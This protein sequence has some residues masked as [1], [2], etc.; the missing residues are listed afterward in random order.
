MS[1]RFA[2]HLLATRKKLSTLLKLVNSLAQKSHTKIE[3]LLEVSDALEFP[4]TITVCGDAGT[5]RSEVA[6]HLL[7][8]KLSLKNKEWSGVDFSGK[9][10][11]KEVDYSVKRQEATSLQDIYCVEAPPCDLITPEQL[12]TFTEQLSKSDIILW[13]FSIDNPWSSTTWGNIE[14]LPIELIDRSVLILN[15]ANERSA[16]D[17]EVM[18]G[19]MQDLSSQRLQSTQTIFPVGTTKQSEFGYNELWTHVNQLLENSQRCNHDLVQARDKLHRVLDTIEETMDKRATNLDSDQ[20]FLASLEADIDRQRERE[21]QLYASKGVNLSKQFV[22]EIDPMLEEL[23]ARCGLTSSLFDLFGR[24]RLTSKVEKFLIDRVCASYVQRS[25]SDCLQILLDCK[26]QWRKMQDHLEERLGADV[27]DFEQEAFKSMLPELEL[28]QEKA[29]KTAIL[30]MKLRHTM[31]YLVNPRRAKLKNILSFNLLGFIV[32]GLLGTFKVP[33]AGI[34][35]LFI[36]AASSIGIIF[37]FYKVFSTRH[38]IVMAMADRMVDLRA[39]FREGVFESYQYMIRE[40]FTGYTPMFE[41]MRR[42]IAESKMNLEPLQAEHHNL[43][44]E[45]KAIENDINNRSF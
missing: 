16:E 21:I 41:T 34:P 20:G 42:K 33:P 43:F 31:D 38:S 14:K 5:H 6:S 27:G 37:L 44:L 39:D 15:K 7:G 35:A 18:L 45:L 11:P 2:E 3:G 22:D 13:V 25:R 36:L 28:K 29:A 23:H 32:A 24:G 10:D 8:T 4:L 1:V 17:I 12:K 19:H 40:F 30:G 26:E 9:I